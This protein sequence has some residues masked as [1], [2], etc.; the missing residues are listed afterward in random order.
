MYICDFVLVGFFICHCNSAETVF[1]YIIIKV[2]F[3]VSESDVQ[4]VERE[5]MRA[6]RD[7]DN[8]KLGKLIKGNLS[9]NT[10]DI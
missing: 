4:R 2:E 7:R 10:T 5:T 3:I 1:K 9:K 8:R 6:R